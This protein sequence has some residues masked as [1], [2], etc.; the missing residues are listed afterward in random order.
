MSINNQTST[1]Q[2]LISNTVARRKFL[3]GILY[4]IG[5]NVS[6]YAIGSSFKDL[7][8]G[9]VAGAKTWQPTG[10]TEAVICPGT[11]WGLPRRV[12]GSPCATLG[13]TGYGFPMCGPSV[14]EME[15]VP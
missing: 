15:C 14:A 5:S 9:M 11:A 1:S 7:D 4:G 3:I 12:T 8:G 2:N 6:L 10:G 13:D